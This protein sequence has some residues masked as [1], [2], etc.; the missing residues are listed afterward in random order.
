MI[1]EIRI[2]KLPLSTSASTQAN[3][4]GCIN[5]VTLN[6]FPF[7]RKKVSTCLAT[8]P[9]LYSFSKIP[10]STLLI[11]NSIILIMIVF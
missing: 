7:Q 11:N 10:Y 9:L 4:V 2:R 5:S 6:V 3:V 8:D 1:N